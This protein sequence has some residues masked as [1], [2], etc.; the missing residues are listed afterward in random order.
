VKA[1]LRRIS[2]LEHSTSVRPLSIMEQHDSAYQE[3][4]IRLTGKR[5]E[6]LEGDSPVIKAVFKDVREG[7]V[8]RLSE[9][10]QDRLIVDLA[11][12]VG[13]KAAPSVGNLFDANEM[14]AMIAELEN[15]L[16]TSADAG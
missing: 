13:L 15:D 1:L 2:K 8:S 9:S 4:S 5:F 10:D 3:A 6:D 11:R 7:F 16:R 14:C 12:A